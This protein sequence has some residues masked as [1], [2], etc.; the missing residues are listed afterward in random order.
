MATSSVTRVAMIGSGGMARHHL[1]GM[2]KQTDTTKITWICEPSP[3][4]Y[5]KAAALF[6]DAGQQPPP[7]EPDLEA[8]L[9]D[10]IGEI[11]V[12]F[13]ITP[14][15]QHHDQTVAAL[16]A[17]LDVLV[18]KPMVMNAAEANSLI[19]VRNKTGKLVVV[20]F[21]GSM[22]PQIRTADKMLRS[23]EMG[24]LLGINAAVWQTWAALTA[25]TWRQD[26]PISGGGYLFDTGAHMLNTVVDLAGEEFTEVCAWIDNRGRAVDIDGVVI[27]R[28]KSGGLVT[29]NGMG[30]SGVTGTDIRVLC[31]NGML[32]TGV[33]GGFLEAQMK[34]ETELKPV[35]VPPSMGT[36][37]Q[38]LRVRRG[39]QANP[40]PPE[41]GLRMARLWDAIQA[42]AA[43]NGQPVLV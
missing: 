42:S 6:T 43:K 26:P 38:F 31:T 11:D 33:W 28:L 12:A 24:E 29:L 39:E 41:V 15:A 40:C 23:G 16:Q 20:A 14:H 19:E 13:I 32:R 22:S 21:N 30:D 4:A 2:L 7:N 17:G 34:G 25:G 37:Q 1:Q 18:E 27:G 9:T 3:A 8:L 36:W 5:E 35:D 10:H